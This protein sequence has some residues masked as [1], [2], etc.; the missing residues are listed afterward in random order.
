MKKKCITILCLLLFLSACKPQEAPVNLTFPTTNG[1]TPPPGSGSDSPRL[2][3][4]TTNLNPTP[5]PDE[6]SLFAPP[7]ANEPTR[8][9]Q[10]AP[11]TF[12]VYSD[13]QSGAGAELTTLLNQLRRELPNDVRIV[14]RHAPKTEA[15]DKSMLAAQAAEAAAE[16]GKFWEMHDLLFSR[17]IE[18]VKQTPADFEQWLTR[19]AAALGLDTNRFS[20]DLKR[21]D[22]FQRIERARL[23][24]Q[25][26]GILITPFVLINGQIYN[27]PLEYE[28]LDRIVRLI[29][30]GKRQFTACPPVIIDSHKQYIAILAT[31][32]GQIVLLLYADKA[33]L[34]VNNFV[35]LARNGWY[36]NI[37]WHRVLPE[38][39]AQTGDPSGTGSGGPGYF[40][41]DEIDPRL[42]F[43]RPGLVA[44][45]NYGP[46][47]N[48][49]QFFITYA[50]AENLNNAYTIFGEVI[51]GME[52][53]RQLSPRDPQP[54]IYL[55]PG[56]PLLSVT[57]EEH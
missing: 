18:W 23:L 49:S 56:D 15:Y 2:D 6:P 48:G 5:G 11:V 54:G 40:F 25:E 57:I 9:P 46:N 22:I 27:G 24:A 4:Q 47:T 37:T 28:S 29:A 21:E 39:L 42:K 45:A 43:D 52:V 3:C 35:F 41:R 30:L 13:F 33:P 38:F 20:A 53:L 12:I 1:T 50:P 19:Q 8:G 31:E 55:P 7:S 36:N 51:S 44:M 16:Q 14:Y 34:T 32:K 17:Q 26:T 10:D